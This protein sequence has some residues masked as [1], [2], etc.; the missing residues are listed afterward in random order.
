MRNL[1]NMDSPIFRALGRL[2]DLMLLN[3]VFIICCIPIV[4]IGAAVT[5]LNYV[6]LKIAEDEEGYIVRGFFRSFRQNFKQ[7]TIIWLI[8]LAFGIVFG[9]DFYILSASTGT[10]MSVFR[11]LITAAAFLYAMVLLYVFPVLA[12]FENS[13]KATIK[14]AFIMAIADFPR[15]ILMLVIT[16]G[17]V[18]ITFFNA[19]TLVYGLLIWLLGG[20]A[21]VAYANSFFMK[22]VLA[23]YMPKEECEKA[24]DPDNW[25]LDETDTA[26][27]SDGRTT[28]ELSETEE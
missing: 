4:T 7:S 11:V 20:F 23:K 8:L 5:A 28:E 14:N 19:Y 27:E 12:R 18:L 25:T 21:L 1:F 24:K 16:V 2:A 9:L 26:E 22:K 15:T 13:I 17:S 10:V 6:T 3:L